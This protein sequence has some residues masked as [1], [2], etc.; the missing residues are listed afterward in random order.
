MTLA[1]GRNYKITAGGNEYVFT[2]P[3][4][5]NTHAVTGIYTGGYETTTN[6]AMYDPYI[7]VTDDN[8]Y[9]SQI[10]LVAA[11]G[12]KIYADGAGNISIEA[13][14]ATNSQNEVMTY[15]FDCGGP[16]TDL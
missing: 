6:T 15:I 9:R 7:A 3:S 5:S 2:M 4:D 1:Y 12:T 13:L 14:P 8:V 11:N 10:R 16:D